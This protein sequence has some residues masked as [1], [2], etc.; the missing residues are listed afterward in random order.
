MKYA[1]YSDYSKDWK[2]FETEHEALVWAKKLEEEEDDEESENPLLFSGG[3][4]I[5]KLIKESCFIEEDRQDNYTCLKNP[6]ELAQCSVCEHGCG[7]G[8]EWP[9]D[10]EFDYVGRIEFQDVEE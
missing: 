10:D 3:I 6:E 7:E 8:E 2:F 9:Y 4:K 5:F 1:V